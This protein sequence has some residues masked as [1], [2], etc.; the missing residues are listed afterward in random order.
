VARTLYSRKRREAER[1]REQLLEEEHKALEALEAKN[2]QLE[3]AK[4][5]AEAANKAKSLFLAN[6]SHEI[7]TP[8]NAILGY[9]QILKRDQ[10]LPGRHRQS[11]ETIEKSGDHL[12]AMINDILDLSKI[13]AGRMELQA[14]DFDLNELIAGITAMF[15]MRCEEKEL[16]AWQRR[17]VYGLG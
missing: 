16:A 5:A 10:E 13:E 2:Q 4:A 11:V 14:S 17:E 12:L 6:M 1:L 9:S 3:S 8:M 7:R 15:R